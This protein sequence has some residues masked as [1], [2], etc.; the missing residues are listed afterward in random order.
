MDVAETLLDQRLLHAF[1][2]KEQ[3]EKMLIEHLD[4]KAKKEKQ[5]RETQNW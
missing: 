4:K 5:R 3:I 2:V 1:L